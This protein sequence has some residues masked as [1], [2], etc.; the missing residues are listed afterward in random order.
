MVENTTMRLTGGWHD[1]FGEIDRA[2]IVFIY[3]P[4]TSGKSSAALSLA[5]E[6]SHHG[7][8]LYVS[9][10]EGFRTSFQNRLRRFSVADCGSKL[11]F[12]RRE[13]AA[14]IL[15]RLA[16]RKSADFIFIDSIQDSHIS[17]KDYNAMKR[18]AATKMFVFVSRIEGRVP[19]GRLARD[20]KFDA[21]LKVWVEGGRAVSEGRYIG[22]VGF[23]DVYED[24][25]DAYWGTASKE[26][27]P[28]KTEEYEE[29]AE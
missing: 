21:D 11:Q 24:K 8:V 3:G 13:P 5:K 18:M 22:A 29:K 27:Q 12:A 9:N 10:E 26:Q 19:M 25:A 4:S 6:L 2:G 16:K 7:R 20:I 15:E 1:C 17:R 23:H 28:D 14:A